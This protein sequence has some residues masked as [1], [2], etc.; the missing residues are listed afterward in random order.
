[1]L[2]SFLY[3]WAFTSTFWIRFTPRFISFISLFL[4]HLLLWFFSLLCRLSF[5]EFH[6]QRDERRREIRVIIDLYVWISWR[7][8]CKLLSWSS[9]LDPL[10]YFFVVV[11]FYFIIEELEY[12]FIS[13]RQRSVDIHVYFVSTARKASTHCLEVEK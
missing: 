9:H 5:H 4:L 12:M 11:T 7:V 6:F 3:P 2:P 10:N 1:M 8:Y 13:D